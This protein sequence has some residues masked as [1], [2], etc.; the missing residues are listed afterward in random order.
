[1]KS[2]RVALAAAALAVALTACSNLQ[3]GSAATVGGTRISSDELDSAVRDYQSALTKAKI[4][5][6]QLQL[7]G[8]IPQ[9]MLLT[10]SDMEQYNQLAAKNGVTV[11]NGEIDQF[12]QQ[13]GGSAAVETVLLQRGVPPKLGKDYIHIVIAAN[14]VAAKLGGGQEEAQ[15]TAGQQKAAE[16]LKTIPVEYNPRYGKLDMQTGKWTASD[17]FVKQPAAPAT[18][19]APPAG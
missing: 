17:S 10:L 3:A 13:Q 15:L 2:V 4:P 14:K 12:I 7:P 9:T 6:D 16:Q 1:M 19:A 5:A 8:S 18:P 11:S